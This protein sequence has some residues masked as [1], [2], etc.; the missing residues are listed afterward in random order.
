MMSQPFDDISITNSGARG[1]LLVGYPRIVA[2]GHRGFPDQSAPAVPVGIAVRHGIYERIDP[3]LHQVLVRPR[4]HAFFSIGTGDAYAGPL[5]TLTR[6]SVTLPG[7]RSPKVLTVSLLADGP[8]GR[9]VPV[10]VT[11]INRSPH[12]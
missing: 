5:F 11:A 3:G 2:A 10:G 1:C 4:H 7:T 9:K 6:L 12:P 8:L